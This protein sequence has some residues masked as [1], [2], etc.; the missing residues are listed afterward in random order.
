[1]LSHVEV[2]KG[3]KYY[4]NARDSQHDTRAGGTFRT[5]CVVK[6]LNKKD[7]KDNTSME[8]LKPITILSKCFRV[9]GQ[10]VTEF[11]QELKDLKSS[12]PEETT[13][14]STSWNDFVLECAAHL[15]VEVDFTIAPVA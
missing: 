8:K 1:M 6:V 5:S 9:S 4:G 11:Q 2:R 3:K 15:G 14:R 12:C 7:K 10:P 13:G